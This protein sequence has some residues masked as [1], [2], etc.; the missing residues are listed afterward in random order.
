MVAFSAVRRTLWSIIII[1]A[2]RKTRERLAG[3]LLHTS[4]RSLEESLTLDVCT[5][6]TANR[7]PC[8]NDGPVEAA[9]LLQMKPLLSALKAGGIFYTGA[10]LL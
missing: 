3:G 9:K 5:R 7:D 4:H 8:L 6:I 1:G 2:S 10:R